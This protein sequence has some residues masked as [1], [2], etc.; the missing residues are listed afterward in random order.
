MNTLDNEI[1]SMLNVDEYIAEELRERVA[2]LVSNGIGAFEAWCMTLEQLGI[3]DES[4]IDNIFY[5][6]M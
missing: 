2:I 1:L 6:M 4:I 3:K 5:I